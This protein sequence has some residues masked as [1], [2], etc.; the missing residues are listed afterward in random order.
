MVR[1]VMSDY[2]VL[3]M[4]RFYYLL[5]VLLCFVGLRV[6]GGAII[7]VIPKFNLSHTKEFCEDHHFSSNTSTR[8]LRPEN[9]VSPCPTNA[10]SAAVRDSEHDPPCK[11]LQITSYNETSL[12]SLLYCS[13]VMYP[14][15]FDFSTKE[16]ITGTHPVSGI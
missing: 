3:E 4:Y 5:G 2:I 7:E 9:F 14:P 13:H 10:F 1:F 16:G 8:K 11:G 12:L 6:V 15:V